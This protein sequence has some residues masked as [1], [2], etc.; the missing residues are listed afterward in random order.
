M[1]LYLKVKARRDAWLQEF[2]TTA[3]NIDDTLEPS[4][5]ERMIVASAH[6]LMERVRAGSYKIILAGVGASNLAAWLATYFLK[7]EGRDVDLIAEV[8]FYGYL[9]RPMDPFILNH[10]N[11]PSCKMTTDACEILGILLSGNPN[12]CIGSLSAAQIDRFGNIN[13]TKI[14]PDFYI[15]GSGGGNDVASGAGEAMVTAIQSK[16]RFLEKVPYITSPGNRVRTL[17]SDKGIF[18]KARGENE[19]V[20]TGYLPQEK[21]SSK[22]DCVREI[23]ASCGWELKVAPDIGQVPLPEKKE[24]SLLRSFDPMRHFLR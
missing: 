21:A 20:L 16:G 9:P 23:K 3:E 24:I 17:V 10:A 2:E 18:E 8:G 4:P 11:I 6:K 13:T 15:T 12:S 1:I 22:E 7:A 5:T 19:F 14:P